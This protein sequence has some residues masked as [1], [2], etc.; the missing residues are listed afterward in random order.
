MQLWIGI[1]HL[2]GL[3]SVPSAESAFVVKTS[4]NMGEANLPPSVSRGESDSNESSKRAGGVKPSV[5]AS[6]SKFLSSK[7][8][9]LFAMDGVSF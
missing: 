2:E 5:L 3:R 4:N 8:T 9:K 1:K 7:L 6:I